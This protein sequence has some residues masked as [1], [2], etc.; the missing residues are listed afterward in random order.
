M[1]ARTDALFCLLKSVSHLTN[2]SERQLCPH[3][4]AASLNIALGRAFQELSPNFQVMSSITQL[5]TRSLTT[6]GCWLS[7]LK[8]N[9]YERWPG[10]SGWGFSGQAGVAQVSGGLGEQ[11]R[12]SPFWSMTSLALGIRG[13]ATEMDAGFP[14]SRWE[15]RMRSLQYKPY[16]LR[17]LKLLFILWQ[18][19]IYETMSSSVG[20]RV[21]VN[22]SPNVFRVEWIAEGYAGLLTFITTVLWENASS[23]KTKRNL[24]WTSSID[25][26]Q[27]LLLQISNF[28]FLPSSFFKKSDIVPLRKSWL[29]QQYM[30]W[31]FGWPH[32]LFERIF[33]PNVVQ[34]WGWV[35]HH[36][37]ALVP[38]WGPRLS[39]KLCLRLCFWICLILEHVGLSLQP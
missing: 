22:W 18:Q 7:S 30:E 29:N 33:P 35:I 21:N 17:V 5:E 25:S 39:Q 6:A 26:W 37:N 8:T 9:E 36:P 4:E 3:H 15:F 19:I 27:P 20:K 31:S 13:R 10:C 23:I 11:E 24:K 38:W 2:T 1:W 34:E 32:Q 16:S 14:I 28:K 12:E